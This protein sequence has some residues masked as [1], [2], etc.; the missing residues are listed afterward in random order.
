MIFDIVCVILLAGGI[1][2]GL[3]KG[4]VGTVS[5]IAGIILGIV[6]G[7]RYMKLLEY[8]LGLTT[9]APVIDHI[10]YFLAIF[11]FT[12]LVF[13]LIG[14][15]IEYFL[16][17][18]LLSWLNHLVGGIV[19]FLWVAVLIYFITSQIIVIFPEFSHYINGSVAGQIILKLM[20]LT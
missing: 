13:F 7:F 20:G 15:L 10:L 14:K 12:V 2:S 3:K 5:G 1:I 19:G 8:T 18:I 9:N 4:F 6:F 16:S 17:L 11:L